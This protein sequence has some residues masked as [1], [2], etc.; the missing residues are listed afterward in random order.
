MVIIEK[1]GIVIQI[2]PFSNAKRIALLN[3]R[4]FLVE[5]ASK[6]AKLAKEKGCNIA[7]VVDWDVSGLLIYL[8]VKKIIPS[9]KR[10]GVDFQ[11]L[12]KLGL[13]IADVE[14]KYNANENNHYDAVRRE[15]KEAVEEIQ[16]KTYRSKQALPE[17]NEYLK[18]IAYLASHLD[19][20]EEKRIEINSI[21]AELNDNAKFWSFIEDEIRDAFEDRLFTR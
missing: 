11:T 2:S 8:K 16:L 1:E 20:L 15:L 18:E 17:D 6:L 13:R 21:T 3:T 7:I 4:G 10:I 5:Y 14:E 12:E 9:L 19:Y